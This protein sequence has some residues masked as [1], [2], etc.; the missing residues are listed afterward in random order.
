[1]PALRIIGDTTLWQGNVP[2][3]LLHFLRLSRFPNT[4]LGSGVLGNCI[5]LTHPWVPRNKNLHVQIHAL[6]Y[7][8]RPCSRTPLEKKGV[9]LN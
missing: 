6:L 7:L 2:T 9:K 8:L 5:A 1:M 3:I 4:A